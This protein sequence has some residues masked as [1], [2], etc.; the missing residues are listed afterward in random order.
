MYSLISS[1]LTG[2]T[3]LDVEH[4]ELVSAINRVHEAE[5]RGSVPDTVKRLAEFK[6]HLAGH[7]EHEEGYF[8]LH[9]YPALDAHAKHHAETLVALERIIEDL[10]AGAIELGEIAAECF[11]ELLDTILMMDMRFLNWLAERERLA[12]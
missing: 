1:M 2:I 7:F 3:Q 12:G 8:T 9:R 5:L 6:E 11:N 10:S 4:H